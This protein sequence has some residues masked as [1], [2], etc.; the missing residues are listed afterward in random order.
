MAAYG[1]F[2]M[3]AVIDARGYVA[4]A[5]GILRMARSPVSRRVSRSR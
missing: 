1:E 4:G 3:A 5:V 2:P